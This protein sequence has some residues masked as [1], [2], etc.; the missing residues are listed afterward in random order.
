MKKTKVETEKNWAYEERSREFVPHSERG[1]SRCEIA[2]FE[3]ES[4][5]FERVMTGE[6]AKKEGRKKERD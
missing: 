3:C 5:S 6:G 4:R 1:A 2:H